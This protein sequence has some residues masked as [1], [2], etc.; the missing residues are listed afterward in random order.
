[1]KHPYYTMNDLMHE[2][3]G[4]K[5]RKICIDGG[6]TCPNRDGTCGTGGC[7]FCGER[8]AGEQEGEDRCQRKESFHIIHSS[9]HGRWGL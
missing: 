8:G 3:Y 1:M 7:T 2:H 6:F 9:F 5:I 4:K